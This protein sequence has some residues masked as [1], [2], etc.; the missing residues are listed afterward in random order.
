[1]D[2]LGVYGSLKGVYEFPRVYWG[3]YMYSRGL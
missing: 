3:V 2:P 1:V